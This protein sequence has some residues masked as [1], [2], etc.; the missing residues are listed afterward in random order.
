MGQQEDEA[1][2]MMANAL[3]SL[4]AQLPARPQG[5]LGSRELSLA[6][7]RRRRAGG[8]GSAGAGST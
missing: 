5:L 6:W 8:L 3:V 4:A 1:L 7:L 2:G